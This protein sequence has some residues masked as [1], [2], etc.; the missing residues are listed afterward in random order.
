MAATAAASRPDAR[1]TRSL[2]TG[3]AGFIGSHLVAALLERGDEIL[4]VDDLSTGK[5]SNIGRCLGLG[6]GVRA[7]RDRHRRARR[8]RG[9]DRR[10][11]PGADLPRRRP[12]RRAQGDRRPRLRRA[13]QRGRHDRGARGGSPAGCPV[14]F[15]ST[16]GASYGEGEGRRLPFTEKDE[17]RP[18]TAYGVSKLAA[19]KYVA[20]YRL[21]YGVPAVSLRL[22]NVYGPRQ[23]PHGEAG[24]VAIFCGRLLDGEAPIVFGDGEQ[25]RDYIYVGDIVAG[26]LAAEAGLLAGSAERDVY[27]IGTG[28]ETSVL[29]IAAALSRSPARARARV[30]AAS[31]RRDPARRD[32][33]GG[34]GAATSA[35][36]PRPSS[37]R[38]SPRPSPGPGP[39]APPGAPRAR[40]I[41]S[42]AT[43]NTFAPH[44]PER[45]QHLRPD[46]LLRG[47]SQ[48]CRARPAA[49]LGRARHERDAALDPGALRGRDRHPDRQPGPAGRGLQRRHR[50][51]QGP[52]RGRVDRRR[53]PRGVRRRLR[54]A[55][56]PR[57]RPLRRRLPAVHGARAGR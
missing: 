26:L 10:L 35:G 6:R 8:A 25:T 11:A 53:R 3:G 37:S 40:A 39:N 38:R 29:E 4:I 32:L 14:V 43:C 1:L 46:R 27:N 42:R 30:P 18:E 9:G 22:G 33:P 7:R 50:Q 2:V 36:R 24:V 47:R 34:S 12:G 51:G 55:R 16:G 56:D 21:L 5:R 41:A 13:G 54:A 17:T 49:L 20:F 31:H 44:G 48:E 52:R 23:D 19:E 57:Q 15:T 45:R 28:V